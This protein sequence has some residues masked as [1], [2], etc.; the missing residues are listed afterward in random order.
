MSLNYSSFQ[1]LAANLI[2]NTFGGM[3]ITVRQLNNNTMITTG[4]FKAGT[5]ENI[6]NRGYATPIGGLVGEQL[7]LPGNLAWVP[8]VGGQVEYYV[9]ATKWIQRIVKVDIV[10]PT[11]TVILYILTVE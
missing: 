6:D 4:V 1:T 7:Y 11:T 3:S 8:D 10:Q 5:T 9:G 2:A